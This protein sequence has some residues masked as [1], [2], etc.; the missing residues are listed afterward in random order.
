[1]K[2]DL[3]SYGF[4]LQ[5]N[6]ICSN[7]NKKLEEYTYDL[8]N[9]WVLNLELLENM[10][11]YH[12]KNEKK[13]KSL[14]SCI[15]N[16]KLYFGKIKDLRNE[17][18]KLRSK[19]LMTQQIYQEYQRRND[20]NENFY[21]EQIE[22]IEENISKKEFFLKQF[23]KKFNEVEIYVQRE[24][25]LIK[26]EQ[27]FKKF[28]FFKILTFIN[29]NDALQYRKL[30]LNEGITKALEELKNLKKENFEMKKREKNQNMKRAFDKD[31]DVG[32]KINDRIIENSYKRK[33]AFLERK[34]QHLKAVYQNLL[35]KINT[36]NSNEIGNLII[37][38]RQFLI[39]IDNEYN[40]YA[41]SDSIPNTDKRRNY[42]SKNSLRRKN[43]LGLNFILSPYANNPFYARFSDLN[44]NS[45]YENLSFIL[46]P[47]KKPKNLRANMNANKKL[48]N[49]KN[50]DEP[51]SN[52]NG[53]K[54]ESLNNNI[55][56][57][58]NTEGTELPEKQLDSNKKTTNCKSAAQSNEKFLKQRNVHASKKSMMSLNW[59][60]EDLKIS[61]YKYSK[62]KQ[63]KSIS[64]K[65]QYYINTK[66]FPS[67]NNK[68]SFN[69]TCN[70]TIKYRR[71]GKTTGELIKINASMNYSKNIENEFKGPL[72]CNNREH[73]NNIFQNQSNS[74]TFNKKE[75]NNDI[76]ILQNMKNNRQNNLH[77]SISSNNS[78]AVIEDDIINS[79]NNKKNEKSE[80]E[81]NF[82][83]EKF[84]LNESGI[85]I[86][87]ENIQNEGNLTFADKSLANSNA[88]NEIES[89][90]TDAI[91]GMADKAIF[92]FESKSPC[93]NESKKMGKDVANFDIENNTIHSNK[94]INNHDSSIQGVCYIYSQDN[95]PVNYKKI[96]KSYNVDIPNM[97]EKSSFL[98]SRF[99]SDSLNN[100]KCKI[101]SKENNFYSVKK[102]ADKNNL[103]KYCKRMSTIYSPKK[104]LKHINHPRND[105]NRDAFIL[106]N[107]IFSDSSPELHDNFTSLNKDIWD[108]SCIHPQAFIN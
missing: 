88:N 69:N 45:E 39:N 42:A 99:N 12:N 86:S 46:S 52:A 51:N 15:N 105:V 4:K 102:K 37:N 14:K 80:N 63:K 78:S 71:I 62:N 6:N 94:N 107:K 59:E 91:D 10:L 103:N 7:D 100:S 17:K 108:I 58:C 33:I 43:S 92:E 57:F 44:M 49:H 93:N 28:H 87:K 11:E 74:V 72:T 82:N 34:I 31:K 79:S 29:T 50:K 96:L 60:V 8:E 41:Y 22:E 38:Y 55:S 61:N 35:T 89:A 81:E 16:C 77:E 26:D 83:S 106:P 9:T 56:R 21:S 2:T 85:N 68:N 27:A 13:Q 101:E 73:N 64:N 76:I 98:S 30:I 47:E 75:E 19:H 32:Q 66:D 5:K 48:H 67:K 97:T 18:Y 104:S 70:S 3:L 84:S 23:E 1:M 54:Y 53:S 36:F 40:T 20:E 65:N 25:K 95:G 90:V 24:S